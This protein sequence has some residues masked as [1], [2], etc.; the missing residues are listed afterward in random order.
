MREWALPWLH[1]VQPLSKETPMERDVSAVMLS[2]LAEAL[3]QPC[4]Q[5]AVDPGR[6]GCDDGVR[7]SVGPPDT[8]LQVA[9]ELLTLVDAANCIGTG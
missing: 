7:T 6:E 9:Q 1:M 2:D 8:A 4:R 3:N 5:G